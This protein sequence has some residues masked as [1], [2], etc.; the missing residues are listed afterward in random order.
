[1]NDASDKN[2][3]PVL[4][5]GI[6]G[7]GVAST[8]FIPGVEKFAQARVVAAADLRRGALDAFERKYGGK[9]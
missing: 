6:A 7:L 3:G 4:R 8:L 9:G 2:S 5:L 1:M